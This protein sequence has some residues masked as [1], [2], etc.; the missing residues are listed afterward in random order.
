MFGMKSKKGSENPEQPLSQPVKV[1]GQ[2]PVSRKKVLVIVFVGLL[3]VATV[4]FSAA[5]QPPVD[6]SE[7]PITTPTNQQLAQRYTIQLVGQAHKLK[8]HPGDKATI[9]Q[10]QDLA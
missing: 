9:S 1:G 10:L 4:L 6:E 2:P 3:G 8:S 5:Q 7:S